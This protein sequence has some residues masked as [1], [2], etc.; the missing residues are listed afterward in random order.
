MAAFQRGISLCLGIS[1][2][3]SMEVSTFEK[4][5]ETMPFLK[6]LM[7]P[8]NKAIEHENEFVKEGKIPS[9]QYIP[10]EIELNKLISKIKIKKLYE[11]L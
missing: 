8:M 6:Y 2:N 9:Y 7:Q 3:F 11:I 10:K 5:V 1:L 4:Q